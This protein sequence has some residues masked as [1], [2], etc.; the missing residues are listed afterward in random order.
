MTRVI[1]ANIIG[2]NI[3]AVPVNKTNSKILINR[4]KMFKLYYITSILFVTLL[5]SCDNSFT[6]STGGK[7]NET[8]APPISVT[9]EAVDN[10]FNDFIHKFSTD[11]AFQLSRTKFPLKIKSYDLLNDK[12]SLIYRDRSE[13][14]MMDFRIK[15]SNGD[16]DNWEQKIVTGK[17]NISVTIQIRGIENGIMVDY[18]FE[19]INGA[20]MLIEVLDDST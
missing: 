14:E 20:W 3:F 18:F 7:S 11:S 9:K 8:Q 2:L 16:Y 1:A 5:V 13:F 10:N 12:D 15:K 4:L 17:N 6:N 19:K